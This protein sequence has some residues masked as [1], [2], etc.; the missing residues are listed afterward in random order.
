MIISMIKKKIFQHK[1]RKSNP[2]N[3]TEAVNCFD[4]DKVS[5]G[6]YTYGGVDVL[7]SG[8]NSKLVIGN[9]CSI[10]SNVFFCLGG[11]HLIDTISSYPFKVKVMGDEYEAISKGDI[12]VGDDVWIGYGAQVMSGVKIGQGAVIAAGAV[13]TKDVPPYA[14]VGGVPAKVI[15]YRFDDATIEKM[16][17]IDYSQLDE[18]IIK[19]NIG[20]LYEPVKSLNQVDWMPKKN[21]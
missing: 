16:L 2:H 5:V 3:Y 17:E 12:E 20:A 4:M 8:T 13:V 10:A 19:A 18:D 14:I 21:G 15:K 6:R 9:F 11:E 1:W 7:N